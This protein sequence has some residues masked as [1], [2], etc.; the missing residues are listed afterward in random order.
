M[1][2]SFGKNSAY[3]SEFYVD[4]NHRGKGIYPAMLSH[5]VLNEHDF[6]RFYISVYKSNSAS[7]NGLLKVG[8]KFYK[9]TKFC[10]F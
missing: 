9:N 2:Y 1:F 8:F 4:A 6:D 5:L 10:G 7:R 3:I